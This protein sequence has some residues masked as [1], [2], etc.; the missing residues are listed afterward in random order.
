MKQFVQKITLTTL[1]FFITFDRNYDLDRRFQLVSINSR[2]SIRTN[3]FEKK[4]DRRLSKRRNNSF[5]LS[6]SATLCLVRYFH[7]S[8]DLVYS[9]EFESMS[10][11]SHFN[12]INFKI[13]ACCLKHFNETISNDEGIF[14]I[15]T[16]PLNKLSEKVSSSINNADD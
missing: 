7:E 4:L 1:L 11:C 2:A 9:F 14:D 13:K 6:S 5:Y 15:S 3:A 12:A 10:K 16:V 8:I